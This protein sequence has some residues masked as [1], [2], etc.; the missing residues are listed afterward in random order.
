ME[1]IFMKLVFKSYATITRGPKTDLVFTIKYFPYKTPVGL[2]VLLD[3]FFS[4]K[5]SLR[6]QQLKCLKVVL[7][8][9]RGNLIY[10]NPSAGDLWW[11]S[12]LYLSFI[13]LFH[14]YISKKCRYL[15][16]KMKLKTELKMKRAWIFDLKMKWKMKQKPKW[17]MK[18]AIVSFPVPFSV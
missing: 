3:F 6:Q 9:P 7:K 2:S 11:D 5:F 16:P 4:G 10:H 15:Q 8:I 14:C 17:E 12:S 13:S 1:T 18:P